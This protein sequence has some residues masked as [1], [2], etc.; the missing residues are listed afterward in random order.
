[1][2][3]KLPESL[4]SALAR[5]GG[6][7]VHPSPDVLTSFMERT[8]P[9]DERDFVT[10]H[11]ALCPDCREV[12][13][14]ASSAAEGAAVNEKGSV[15]AAAGQPPAVLAE[16]PRRRWTFGLSWAVAAVAVLLV[17]GVLVRQRFGSAELARHPVSSVAS[18]SEQPSVAQLQPAAPETSSA[19][20]ALG[21]TTRAT[22]TPP[23]TAAPRASAVAVGGAPAR[24]SAENVPS[25]TKKVVAAP[26]DENAQR[27][28]TVEEAAKLAA[29][30]PATHNAFVENQADAMSRLRQGAALAKPMVSLGAVDAA[31][32]RWR[33]SADGHLEHRV[34]E[35]EWA[36]VLANQ[37]TTFRAVS[38][39]GSD[40]WAGGE[41][42][43]LFRSRDDGLHWRRIPLV[44]TSG[45]ET[46]TITSIKFE[47]SQQ[48]TVLTAAGS[49]WT[50]S[51][52]GLTWT[53]R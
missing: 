3:Q 53:Q 34:A 13:F 8:L 47:T 39:V 11:L 36:R 45:A 15:A 50:T 6:G 2:N 20:E 25:E 38:V 7:E 40:V 27:P 52:G 35:D 43:A 33:I 48:G 31:R 44:T 16:T 9:R 1:M 29:P 17:A 30:V 42:G 23:K 24:Q 37:A 21:K 22:T 51:D 41:G 49:R 32:E 26:T 46:G 28:A 10:N 19:P 18:N 5:Q 14:L 12:V 4:R